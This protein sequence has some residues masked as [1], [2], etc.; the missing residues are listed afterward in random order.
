MLDSLAKRVIWFGVCIAAFGMAANLLIGP[1]YGLLSKYSVFD[2]WV[3]ASLC[4]DLLGL[5]VAFV[6]GLIWACTEDRLISLV[7]W[8]LSV[9]IGAAAV[10]ELFNATLLSPRAILLPA[11]YAAELTSAFI[12]LVAALRFMSDRWQSR[13]RKP[14]Q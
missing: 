9:A 3:T 12:L 14:S 5:L 6:G 10:V 7:A 8:G 11:F 4:V 2:I 13:A 1:L